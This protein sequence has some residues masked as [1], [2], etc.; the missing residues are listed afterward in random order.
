MKCKNCGFLI[1]ENKKFCTNCG[2]KIE[3]ESQQISEEIK[4][5]EVNQNKTS[6]LKVNNKKT[7]GAL[8][9]FFGIL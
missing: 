7:N 5:T 9:P 3:I 8:L 6:S 4:T 1:K 2:F